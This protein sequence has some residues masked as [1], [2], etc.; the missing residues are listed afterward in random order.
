MGC[1]IL[2]QPFSCKLLLTAADRAEFAE[3]LSGIYRNVLFIVRHWC[4]N[5]LA[6]QP[7]NLF[8]KSAS[9]ILPCKLMAH[10]GLSILISVLSIFLIFLYWHSPSFFTI[11]HITSYTCFVKCLFYT[12][13]NSFGIQKL[14][15]FSKSIPRL[16]NHHCHATIRTQ[17]V[18]KQ[19]ISTFW[20]TIS[21]PMRKSVTILPS[22]A[23]IYTTLLANARLARSACKILYMSQ[24]SVMFKSSHSSLCT[25]L[26]LIYY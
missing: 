20:K 14:L 23:Q 1:I 19:N 8:H 17:H 21:F 12:H 26:E 5:W 22:N 10:M 3:R 24:T 9:V 25:R 6:L 7:L 18:S 2:F 11:N 13:T 16:V 4:I 15:W